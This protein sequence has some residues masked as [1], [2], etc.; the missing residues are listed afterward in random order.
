MVGA[1]PVEADGVFDVSAYPDP[2]ELLLA[3]DVLVTDYSSAI[4]DFAS[5]NR[6][7]V[8]FTPD[9]ETYRDTIRG[10]SI[11]FEADAPG[12]LLRTTDDVIDALRDLDPVRASFSERYE[13]FVATYCALND[14]RAATRVV[15]RVFRW[16]LA[17]EDSLL[18]SP[19]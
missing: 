9:L 8:F 14:G 12:P 15:E 2:T 7:V 19:R 6:P 18:E 16:S 1:L 4:F 5:T 11:D 13:R 3:V 17:A 10:F